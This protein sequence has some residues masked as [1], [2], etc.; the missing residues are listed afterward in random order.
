GVEGGV[1]GVHGNVEQ[2]GDRL[3]RDVVL[4]RPEPTGDHDEIR[5][6]ERAFEHAHQLGDVVTDDSLQADVVTDRVEPLGDQQRIGVDLERREQFA[7]NGDNTSLHRE[8]RA[9]NSARSARV[10]YTPA[11]ASSAMTPTPPG[12]RS[13]LSDGYGLTM[14]NNRKRKNATMAPRHPTGFMK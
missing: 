14:S 11:I 2:P 6:A 8:I 9:A 4:G 12:R 13:S 1:V 10:A 7:T 5:P 3:T